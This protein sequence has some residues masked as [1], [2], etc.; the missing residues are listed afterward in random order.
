MEQNITVAA[1]QIYADKGR[2]FD[3]KKYQQLMGENGT[4]SGQEQSQ[5]QEAPQPLNAPQIFIARGV[6]ESNINGGV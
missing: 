5:E 6:Q 2:D 3:K 4:S 1:S